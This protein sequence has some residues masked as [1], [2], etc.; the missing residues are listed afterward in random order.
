MEN[1]LFT[2]ILYYKADHKWVLHFQRGPL[3]KL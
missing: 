2:Y 1:L 3:Q